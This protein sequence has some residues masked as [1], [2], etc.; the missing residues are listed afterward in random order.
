[1]AFSV[2]QLGLALAPLFAGALFAGVIVDD[3]FADANSQ[4]QDLASHSLRIFNG[5]TATVRTDEPGAA[6]FRITS[7]GGSEAF[8]AYFTNAGSPVR[9]GIGDR[10]TVAITFSL[11]GFPAN[12]QDVRF[13]VLDSQGTRNGANLTGGMNDATFSGDTGYSLQYYASG[14][15]VPFNLGR[16]VNLAPANVFNTTADFAPIT[17]NATPQPERRTLSED[18]P[19]TLTY[20]IRRLSATETQITASVS[21]GALDS[22]RASAVESSPD[23]LTTFDYFAFRVTGPAFSDTIRFHRLMAE[24][25]PAPPAILSQPQPSNLTVQVGSAV[26]LAIA[27]SGSG[28]SYQWTRNGQPIPASANASAVTPTL[29]LRNIQSADAGAYGCVVSNSSGSVTSETATLRVSI[30]PVPPPPRI[31]R[32]P[33]P[34]QVIAGRAAEITVEAEGAA[35]VYQWFKD[36]ALIPG[37][38][39]LTLSINSAQAADAGGYRVLV[40]NPSGSVT[41]ET[42][43][44]LV[45]SAISLTGAWPDNLAQNLCPDPQFRLWFDQEPVAGRS[46]RIRFVRADGTVLDT[47]DLAARPVTRTISGAVFAYH[48]LLIEGNRVLIQPRVPL[49]AGQTYSIEIEPGVI[50]D[51]SGLPFAGIGEGQW[52]V[53]TRATNVPASAM[54]LSVDVNGEGQFCT[55]QGGV[56]HV[57]AGNPQRVTITVAPGEYNEIVYVPS[58]KPRITVRGESREGTVIRYPNNATLN[59]ANRALFGVDAADFNLENITLHNT[60]PKGGSQAEAFRGNNERIA[61]TRV[62]LRSFQDTLWLQGAGSVTGSYIEGDVDFLWGGGAVYFRDTE[63]KMLTSSGV[64]TQVRNAQGRYGYVFVNCRFTAAAGVSGSWLSRIDPAVYPYSQAVLVD[65]FLGPHIRPEGWQLNNA[66]L[67]PNVQ[68]FEYGSKDLE[69][70]PLDISQRAPFSRQLSAAEAGPFRNP[71][72]V[73][74]GWTPPSKLSAA[75]MLGSLRTVYNGSPQPVA[76]TTVPHGLPVRVAY[77]GGA[78]APSAAGTYTVT[79]T[80]EHAD[81]EGSVTATLTIEPA[82]VLITLTRLSQTYDGRPKPVALRSSPELAAISITYDGAPAP[83]VEPG[84]YAVQAMVTD[85]NYRGS[86]SATLSVLR[87]G[88]EALPA[89]P[90]AEG[91]GAASVGGRGGDVYHVTT[92]NDSGAGSLRAAVQT[93]NG[94]RTIVF[95]LSGTVNLASRLTI[96]KANLTIAGE[97]A[98]GDGITLAGWPLVISN[99]HD[100]IV[101]YIRVRMG[102]R[103]C[104]AVQDDALSVD[105]SSLVILD[106]VSASWSIDETLSVTDSDRVTV[107]WSFIT[108]SLR[109]SCHEKGAHGYG[110]L[111]RYGSGQV[112]FHHNLYAHHDS[113]NPRVGDEIGLDFTNNVLYDY[114]GEAGYSGEASEGTT[115]INYAGNFIVPGPSTSASRRTRAFS[116]GSTATVLYQSNNVI[117]SVPDDVLS[118]QDTGW[119]MFAGAYTRRTEGRFPF[120]SVEAQL[121]AEALRSVLD[122]AGCSLRRDDVDRRIAWEVENSRGRIIDSQSQVD[123]WPLL[124]SLPPPL[125]TDRDGIPDERETAH[126]LNPLDA[127]DGRAVTASGYTNLERYLHSLTAGNQ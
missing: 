28:L 108:E 113:R 84:I 30:D 125:D 18:T 73:L 3:S 10:L 55:V 94:P 9:L 74:G 93:A 80:V 12:G 90:G 42:A 39:S 62:T 59:S 46:G 69:G 2:R 19:Y 17:G 103:N 98:P 105:R 106:H 95:D 4:N 58:N 40:S 123:G 50:T 36:G 11:S 65:S 124:R 35:L 5:R 117:D 66:T 104:P 22:Y 72:I 89:F 1:M 109:N 45:L 25:L 87:S 52:R 85:T 33:V 76:A 115:R 127:A 47:I 118:G 16:R 78:T 37:A 23:P 92:L 101:R 116:G 48:P 26:S 61:L 6:T 111:L 53:S 49:A 82:P 88:T 122:Q 121:P 64:Y 41:S 126:G 21:G 110:T 67:A 86:A 68:F 70:K 79:A 34:V 20:E 27:A 44:L 60:T 7:A 56:D 91:A 31:T 57:P 51:K 29:E 114:G 71:A 97:T 83:P 119:Q 14:A 38:T 81:Y 54:V 99:T 96:N 63:L 43:R 107:Q 100:V 120:A 8:W 102:D 112:S 15:G 75:I 13:G 77:N 32:Q 24:Y